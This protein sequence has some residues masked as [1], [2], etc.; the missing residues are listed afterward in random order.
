MAGS[1]LLSSRLSRSLLLESGSSPRIFL[2]VTGNLTGLLFQEIFAPF[3]I[4]FSDSDLLLAKL[5]INL[6]IMDG[7]LLAKVSHR[8]VGDL[9]RVPVE[10][11]AQRV[12]LGDGAV[13]DP[14]ELGTNISRD[15]GVPRRIEPEY[16]PPPAPVLS[17]TPF[18]VVLVVVVE[19]VD[20]DLLVCKLVVITARPESILILL[21]TFIKNLFI[22]R[23]NIEATVDIQWNI[24]NNCRRV[25]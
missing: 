4:V 2:L 19:Q 7:D 25:I 16:A 15:T 20:V 13:Q 21:F 17:P 5:R 9:H 23:Q 12:T 11:P 14:Q 3:S 10:Q 6:V 24:A 22:A 18:V 1:L 8:A